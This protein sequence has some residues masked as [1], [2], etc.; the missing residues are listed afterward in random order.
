MTRYVIIGAGAVGVT[1]AVELQSSGREVVLVGRGRQLELLQAGQVRYIRPDATTTVEVPTAGGPDEVKLD[2]KDILI[3][4]TKTQDA[5]DVLARWAREPVDGGRWRAGEVLPVFTL[6][7]GLDAERSA[8][9]RFATVV[10]SV[11]AVPSTYITDGEILAPAPGLFWLGTYPDAAPSVAARTIAGDLSRAGF[12]TQVV[13]DLSRWKTWK[14]VTSATFVLDALYSAG[15]ERDRAARL[16]RAETLQILAAAGLEPADPKTESTIRLDLLAG[17]PIDA[18]TRPGSSTYQSLARGRDVETD[19]L[20]GEVALIARELRRTAPINAALLARV[21]RAV[22]EGTA[23]GSLP[24]EDLAAVLASATVLIEAGTLS[25]ELAG[26]QPPAVLDVRWALGDPDGEKHYLDGHLPSAVFV[27]LDRELAATPSAHAGRHPLPAITQLQKAAR[28]WGLR[29]GQPVV[30][31]DNNGG[32]SASRAWWLLRWAGVTNVRILDGGL[33]AWTAAG[34]EVVSGAYRPEPGDVEL[35]AG[36]L[37]VLDADTAAALPALGAGQ[38]ALIDARA[39]ERYRGEV[40]P[41]DPRAGHVPGAIN[42]P[43]GD[44]LDSAGRFR[45]VQALRDRFADVSAVTQVGVYCGSGVTAAHE[46][47]ALQIA[48]ID[49]ALYPG[50]WSAWSSDPTRPVATGAEPDPS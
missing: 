49:A 30:V 44:N 28:S 27:D 2:H 17:Q 13:A 8:L 1:L 48:G 46:I 41:I 12:E 23:P 24:L 35:R 25:A 21:H 36:N 31:Y 5:D 20:N 16:V 3:L 37:P 26:S 14:L 19:Y 10:G 22:D 38:G 45:S 29:D 43:T 6:Q 18:K 34:S 47:A 4:A 15:P 33:G 40:E 42:R 50:S 11:L 9:R 39:G 32:L 7:N